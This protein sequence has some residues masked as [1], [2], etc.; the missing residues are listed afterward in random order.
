VIDLGTISAVRLAEGG[1]V[2]VHV[3]PVGSYV[4]PV[5][6]RLEFTR[7]RLQRFADQVNQR[8][9]GVALAVDYEHRADVSKGSRAAG[10]ITAAE[11][12]ADGLWIAVDW[13]EEARREIRAGHW[14]YFSPEL[15]PWTDPQT[16]ARHEDMLF[17]GAITNRPFLRGLATLVASEHGAIHPPPPAGCGHDRADGQAR[18]AAGRGTLRRAGR[19]ACLRGAARGSAR[20][21][22]PPGPGG[23]CRLPAVHLQRRPPAGVVR[24]WRSSRT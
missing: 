4:H 8:A 20:T 3:F 15:G 10:W 12:R 17:G 5:H 9:R 2:W 14:R 21:G 7:Q 1:P 23:L 19:A 22:Q 11:V 13:M 16:G 18:R 24:A 6:G